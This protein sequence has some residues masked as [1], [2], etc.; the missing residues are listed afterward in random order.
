MN[1]FNNMSIFKKVGLIFVLSVVIFTANLAIS[2]V[3]INKNRDTM[4]FMQSKVSE[5]VELANQNVIF[6]QRLDELYTQSV[7]FA[8]EDLL[9]NASKVFKSLD[10][11]LNKLTAIDNNQSQALSVLT[12]ALE[13]YNEMTSDLARGMLDGTI[14]MSQVGQISQMKSAIFDKLTNGINQYKT[15]KVDEFSSTLAEASNRSEQS[16]YLTLGIGIA[17]LIIMGIA[18]ISIAR[19]ISGSAS[20]V[21][22]SLG[23]LADGKGN[24]RH[25][26]NVNGTDELGQV[27]S[28][29]NRFLRLLADSIQG[30]VSV[31][32]PL[33]ESAKSLKDKMS[34]A[35]KATQQQ[36]Q[37]ARTVHVSMEEM[38]HSVN[39]ISLSAQ[40]AAEAAQEAE[41][42]ATAGLA[43]VQRTINISQDLNKGIELAAN[44]INELARDTESVGSILNVITSIAEQTNLLA[45]NAA[46]EAARAG[47]QGRGFAVV[48]DE[49]RALAS[50]TADA[51]KEIRG[52]LDRLKG[53][54]ESSV[55]TMGAAITKSSDNERYAKD[56]GDALKSI[57]AKIVSINSMNTHIASATDQQS[58]VAEQVGGNVVEMNESF[59]YSLSI[60]AEVHN[61]S[62]GLDDFAIQLKNATSQFK[63]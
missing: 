53:A 49:V 14:D 10:S 62:Q 43:V 18:T 34:I 57:Q 45:L 12:L 4:N 21:A 55:T 39:D 30:V 63:L 1:W 48:A 35:T 59:E 47:E 44:S 37:D 42:E 25:Q 26:L 22:N 23:E 31:T 16:L 56:T 13:E 52:V 27:S 2:I 61:I 9:T 60:L 38:R 20:N 29:F 40:Q 6:V 17:L 24:L 36:S 54:A 33:L 41:R 7:S 46:I 8:D 11:N 28:N 50:K 58:V 5:R 15:D 51:T 19:S 32:N 3:A